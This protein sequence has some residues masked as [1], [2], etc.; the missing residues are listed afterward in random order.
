M[1]SGTLV[2]IVDKVKQAKFKPPAIIIVGET[3]NLRTALQWRENKPLWGARILVTR[4]RAQASE[5]LEQIRE[6]GGE[7][8]EF[9]SIEIVKETD[10]SPLYLAFPRL[11]K[12]SW[13][14]FTSVN[15]VDIFFEAMRYREVDIR[16]LQGV[17]ICAIGP[18]T[19]ERLAQRGLLVDLV[20]EEYR[21]EGIIS[22]LLTR[23]KPGE[24]IL[25]PP[26]GRCP[27]DFTPAPEGCR[28]DR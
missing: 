19:A 5:L 16:Q 17:K 11:A 8:L 12:Y 7:A 13:I 4:A 1:V 21:A 22:E 28:G 23:L 2:N 25:D 15:A 26:R 6:A 20:P 9:P 10:L 18:A 27:R 3:V 14:I 24:Q